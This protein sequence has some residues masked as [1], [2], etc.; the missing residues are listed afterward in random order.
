VRGALLVAGT[1]SD[2][3]KSVVVAGVCR[4]LA[5]RGVRVAP[6]K[7]QNMSLNSAVT[8]DGAEIGR[9]QFAQAQAAGVVPEAVMNPVLLKPA[10]D[11]SS[12]VVVM[13]R[14]L[15]AIDAGGYLDLKGDLLPV[16]LE[17]L[18]S[19]RTRFDVVVCEGAGSLAEINLREGDLVNMGLARAAGLPIVVVADI[20]RGGAFASLFGSLALLDRDD[21]ALVSGFL[22]NKF[23]GDLEILGPAIDRIADL[24]GRPAL[25]V[26]PWVRGLWVDAED[27]V[28]LD[29]IGSE[30]VAP[31][32]RDVL[33]VAILR[34][35]RI[36][37]FTD[38]DALGA[39]PGVAVRLTESPGEVASAD[40]VVIPGTK[41][42]VEDLRWLRSRG[43]DDALRA[44][45]ARGNPVIGM[46]GGYQ[47]LGARIED[48]VESGAGD[49]E[50]LGLLP[51]ETV[52]TPDK[53][54][55]NPRGTAPDFGAVAVGGYEI[56]HGRVQRGGGEP[57]FETGEGGEGCRVG[58][59]L[60]TSW[61]GVFES[62]AFRR[63]FLCWVAEVRRLAW[64]PGSRPFAQL[65]ESRLDRLG[66]LIERHVDVDAL[67]GLIDR[68]A[69]SGLPFVT[70]RRGPDT[71]QASPLTT[72]PRVE[73]P[74]EPDLR[75]HGDRLV[76][77]GYLDFA[78]NVVS[79]GS[80]G[81]LLEE[82]AAA[83][84]HVSSYPDE[85]EAARALA[86]RHGRAPDE[87]LPTN[88][89][90]EAFWL[91]ATALSSR[92]AVV[93]HPMFTEA[94]VALRSL[95][96]LAERVF[97]RALD[98]SFDPTA[99]PEAA[100]L[101]ILGNPNNPT[102]T[103]EPAATI[104]RLTRPGRVVAVDEAFME[105]VP[106][107]SESLSARRDLPDLVVIRSLTKVWSIP[108]VRAGYVLGPPELLAALRETRQPWAVNT[109]A[110]A[111][112]AACARDPSAAQKVAGEVTQHREALGAALARLP[113]VRVWP[114]A[115]NFVLIRVPDG[116]AVRARLLARGIAVR[117]ADTFPGLT[118]N[119]LRIAVR[120][121]EDNKILVE[122]IR[123][124][125]R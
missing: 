51:V 48:P 34:L 81:W 93:I 18:D 68:G 30:P 112:L 41:A 47:M 8:P 42:T 124:A 119:H 80:P 11:R 43:L 59:V 31:I 65:R 12:Q 56:R 101:V 4:M 87:V 74:I 16:V 76:P 92:H 110:L 40:L 24:T 114:S 84:D 53:L 108:G 10:T 118:P 6:F 15:T 103:L 99:V 64:L 94:E 90:A 14:P 52:F 49:V 79:E 39:E 5:R 62:D 122:S 46:C 9:A 13:G 50:G 33:T 102:G 22:L 85:R 98:F 19:L 113:G 97:R 95:G 86:E 45:A 37:N 125:L 111:A 66:D 32:G 55:G 106:D 57:L 36:S 117:R 69:P 91:L 120:R 60:G 107:E 109:L 23:R 7:A 100:D 25:G 2:V 28:A 104:E 27:S 35:P 82:L 3:G 121:P 1:S 67:F 26:L 123:E 116:P 20:D 63:A 70:A 54:L 29:A 58:A 38:A 73:R 75:V 115:A 77:P 105:F 72:E 88:G 71:I 44:R 83:L 78:V 96:L 89:A 17:A 21:Q 61:H